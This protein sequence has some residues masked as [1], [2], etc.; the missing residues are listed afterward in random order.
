MGVST[1]A[2]IEQASAW[3]RLGYSS[4]EASTE[5]AQLSSQFASISPGMSTETAQTGLVSLMKAYDIATDEVERKL[6]DNINI[7]GK[8]SCPN[9]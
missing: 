8:K 3:S 9:S 2:I 1:T 4:K 5:M 7:L 6:M